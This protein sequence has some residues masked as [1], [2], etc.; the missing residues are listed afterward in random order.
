MKAI[1]FYALKNFD[2][3]PLPMERKLSKWIFTL[4]QSIGNSFILKMSDEVTAMRSSSPTSASNPV[5]RA[6]IAGL[7]GFRIVT[8]GT[9]NTIDN[10]VP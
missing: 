10:A 8:N 6:F 2:N 3:Q 5:I 4:F 9:L 7:F 1:P